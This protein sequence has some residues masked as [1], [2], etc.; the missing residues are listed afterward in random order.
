MTRIEIAQVRT[1]GRS[2]EQFSSSNSNQHS[3][4]A[5][6]LITTEYTPPPATA[7][8]DKIRCPFQCTLK[9]KKL[10]VRLRSNRSLLLLSISETL[11]WWIPWANNIHGVIRNNTQGKSSIFRHRM[12]FIPSTCLSTP[13]IE[14][15]PLLNRCARSSYQPVW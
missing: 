3:H 9:A 8:F 1:T 5:I 2:F 14:R 12:R 10:T 11:S 13:W 4:P 7:G 6:S 15:S